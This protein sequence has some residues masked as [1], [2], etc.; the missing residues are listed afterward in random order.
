MTDDAALLRAVVAAADDDAP[1]LV[2]ADWLDET[3]ESEQAE[4]I[5][6]DIRMEALAEDDPARRALG[7]RRAA[8]IGRHQAAWAGLDPELLRHVAPVF[9]RGLVEEL[10]WGDAHPAHWP[11]VAGL[12]RDHPVRRL[13]IAGP[14]PDPFGDL[15]PPPAFADFAG[16]LAADPAA[17]RLARLDLSQLG[18]DPADGLGRLAAAATGLRALHVRLPVPAA[19]VAALVAGPAAAGIDDLTV[20]L[21]HDAADA[22]A[23]LAGSPLAARLRA[24]GLGPGLTDGGLRAALGGV[25]P[26][27]RDLSLAAYNLTPAAAESLAAWAGRLDRFDLGGGDLPDG[28]VAALVRA[29]AAAAA[30]TVWLSFLGQAGPATL[31][32]LA[33]PRRPA[34]FRQLTVLFTPADDA[35][36]ARL[37]ASP[38]LDGV[39]RLSLTGPLRS[40]PGPRVTDAGAEA[41]ARS[42]RLREVRMLSLAHQAI[43]PAGARALARS[44]ALGRLRDLDLSG[45]PVGDAGAAALAGAMF[46][47][48]LESLYLSDCGVGDDGARAL[49]R[50]ALPSLDTLR[51][52]ADH[53][54][55]RV[56]QELRDRFGEALS[57]S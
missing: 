20:H 13:D 44:P 47:P 31:A 2:F 18:G 8:L 51:L 6:L 50:A 29:P 55:D 43:G 49:M 24:L 41:V 56:R 42:P 54:S 10:H 17:A 11:V 27:L 35:G 4:F 9:H 19:G 57:L 12:L 38:A 15:S 48:R 39:E 53:L 46:A 16:P 45:D 3:G 14:D 5:R 33:D 1:R 52:S 23:A 37:A 28:A 21:G 30:A 34:R 22:C 7:R 36:V 26:A 40:Y 32:A 25:G